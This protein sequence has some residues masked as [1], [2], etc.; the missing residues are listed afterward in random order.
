[1]GNVKSLINGHNKKQREHFGI[2]KSENK[3]EPNTPKIVKSEPKTGNAKLCN[4]QKL[5][6]CPV[7]GK[8]LLKCCIYEAV[9]IHESGKQINE[10]F[11]YIGMTSL[12]FKERYNGHKSSLRNKM[13]NQTSLSKYHH[14]LDDLGIEHRI[15]W[16][17]LESGLEKWDG[18]RCVLCDTEKWRILFSETPKSHQ[19]NERSELRSS[20]RH[21]NKFTKK[22]GRKP[23]TKNQPKTEVK[24]EITGATA[25]GTAQIPT[26]TTRKHSKI[27]S[28]CFDD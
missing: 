27:K 7:N 9:I 18:K 23:G 2:I 6:S 5:S 8:C 19:L 10:K 26:K 28:E 21:M 20:C 3:I 12:T 17:I 16:Q 22:R 15:E 14:K 25:F 24:E 1:M 11:S 13:T 4:C